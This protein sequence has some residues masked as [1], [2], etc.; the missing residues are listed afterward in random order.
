MSESYPAQQVESEWWKRKIYVLYTPPKTNMS[1][2]NWWLEDVI[3]FWN[4][5]FFGAMLVFWGD[6]FNPKYAEKR[7]LHPDILYLGSL[8]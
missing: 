1:P 8:Q 7:C 4:G 2:E 5:P 6:M 3:S